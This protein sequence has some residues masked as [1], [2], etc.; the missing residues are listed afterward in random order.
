MVKAVPSRLPPPFHW[1]EEPDRKRLCL[2]GVKVLEIC[3]RHLGWIVE[4]YLHE[5]SRPL[6]IIAVRSAS[7]GMRWA[8]QHMRMLTQL[9]RDPCAPG[10]PAHWAARRRRATVSGPRSERMAAATARAGPCPVP[11]WVRCRALST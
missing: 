7:A 10:H 2:G 4:V 3:R 8:K 6:P 5:P 11:A 1:V 9:A